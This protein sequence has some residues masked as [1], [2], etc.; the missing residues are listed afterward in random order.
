MKWFVGCMGLV[1]AV[2]CAPALGTIV[3]DLQATGLTVNVY[4]DIPQAD[5]IVGWGMDLVDTPID[6]GAD[7]VISSVAINEGPFDAAFAPDGDGLA[8]LVTPP[9]TPVWGDDIL[10]ATVDF[11]M[12]SPGRALVCGEDTNPP[13]LTEGFA[14]DPIV[15]GFA[16]VTYNCVE[17][18]E[19]ATLALLALGGLLAIR[20]R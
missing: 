10:L 20:R 4:A 16:D 17:I 14:L 11:A 9:G 12:V 1:L 18:P 15:G 19:P 2:S 8:A 13:D 7:Y 6:A 5:A 3:V